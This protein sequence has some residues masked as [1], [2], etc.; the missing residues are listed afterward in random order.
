[1]TSS[2]FSLAANVTTHHKMTTSTTK[3]LLAGAQQAAIRTEATTR[4]TSR[5]GL[6]TTTAASS[7]TAFTSSSS[8][9]TPTSSSSTPLTNC[10]CPAQSVDFLQDF[11]WIIALGL[12]V[13]VVVAIMVTI[14]TVYKIR[15]NYLLKRQINQ[16][17]RIDAQLGLDQKYRINYENGGFYF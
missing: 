3:N 17:K 1:M 12:V 2:V 15:S 8:S 6:S 10:S 4:L 5:S 11:Q 16:F 14:V 13:F 7:S 9:T